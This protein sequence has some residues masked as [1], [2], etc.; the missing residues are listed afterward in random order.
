MQTSLASSSPRPSTC[1]LS[2]VVGLVFERA[3]GAAGGLRSVGTK[4]TRRHQTVTADEN[5]KPLSSVT[6]VINGPAG[7]F[8]SGSHRRRW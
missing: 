3:R 6:I 1:I 4:R 8:Q 7:E 5:G 2:C